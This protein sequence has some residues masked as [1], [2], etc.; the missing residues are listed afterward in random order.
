MELVEVMWWWTW[1]VGCDG[2]GWAKW[3][4][5]VEVSGPRIDCVVYTA[6]VSDV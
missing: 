2:D 3:W 4:R 6:S 5:K 1:G